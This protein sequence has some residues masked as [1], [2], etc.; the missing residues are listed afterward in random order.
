MTFDLIGYGKNLLCFKRNT[1]Q[2]AAEYVMEQIRGE[3]VWSSLTGLDPS[4]LK[5]RVTLVHQ[6]YYDLEGN[7][8]EA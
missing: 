6:E 7:P 1:P 8:I 5:L 4:Q 2:E 3:G